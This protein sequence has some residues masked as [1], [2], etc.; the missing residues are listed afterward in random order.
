MRSI[1]AAPHIFWAVLFIILPLLIV[2]Y[3]A[4]TDADGAPLYPAIVWL[5]NRASKEAELIKEAFGEEKVYNRN[6]LIVDDI[7]DSGKTLDG[8]PVFFLEQCKKELRGPAMAE[9]MDYFRGQLITLT[10]SASNKYI[11]GKLFFADDI[12]CLDPVKL[13]SLEDGGKIQ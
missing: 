1:A 11:F 7:I 13:A 9:G 8:A 2:V 5:D 6:C 4:F 10:E 3:Y 12:V